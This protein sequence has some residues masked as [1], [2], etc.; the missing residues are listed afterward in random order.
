MVGTGRAYVLAMLLLSAS[1]GA[2][3]QTPVQPPVPPQPADPAQPEP[4][5]PVDA[6]AGTSQDAEQQEPERKGRTGREGRVSRRPSANESTRAGSRRPRV[7][8]PTRQTL[9]LS[10]SA[11]TGYDNNSGTPAV[12]SGNQALITESGVASSV[13]GALAYFRGNDLRSW[14]IDTN[15][16]VMSYPAYLTGPAAGGGASIAGSMALGRTTQMDVGARVAYEPL[17]NVLSPAGIGPVTEAPSGASLAGLVNQSSI[18]VNG[19][20][21]LE[22]QTG[23][24]AATTVLYDRAQRYFNDGAYVDNGSDSVGITERLGSSS[25]I[26]GR[27]DY[28]YSRMS[29]SALVVD[30]SA[31]TTRTHRIEGGPEYSGTIGRS[32]TTWKLM[33]LFGATLVDSVVA[34]TADPYSTWVPSGSGT[35]RMSNATGTTSVDVSYRRDFAPFQGATADVY[36]NDSVTASLARQIASRLTTQ[37]E[38]V[39]TTWNSPTGDDATT[40]TNAADVIGGRASANIRLTSS[41]NA[42]VSYGYYR[43]RFDDTVQL[44]EDFPGYYDRNAFRVGLSFRVPIIGQASRR[45]SGR[46][47]P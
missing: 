38:L 6:A 28:R 47:T 12:V 5:A 16:N 44:P 41:M 13:D 2:R 1:A 14:Q 15:G 30:A 24:R 35:F 32:G 39:F 10:A 42:T 17:L 27:M 29:T 18:G 22:Q 9:T 34:E 25:G 8:G 4:A 26:R 19:S 37:F 33:A 31:I 45:A 36:T 3:A 20:V 40:V 43:Q 21:S 46:A 23:E 11:L 7:A